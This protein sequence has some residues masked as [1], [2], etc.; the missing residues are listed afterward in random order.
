MSKLLFARPPLDTTE[1]LTVRTLARSRHASA[2]WILRA[3]MIQRSWAGLRTTAIAADLHC[4]P[5]TVRERLLRFNADR[6]SRLSI[7]VADLK[8]T[9]AAP[10]RS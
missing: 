9:S 7:V 6:I 1:E 3:R 4:H 10:P 5:Q 8:C 2:D